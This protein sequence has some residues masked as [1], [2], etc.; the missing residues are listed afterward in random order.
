VRKANRE[1][2][3]L[4]KLQRREMGLATMLLCVVVVFLMCNVLPLVNNILESFYSKSI[5]HLVQTSNFLVVFNSS[6]NFVIYC[7]CGERFRRLLLRLCRDFLWCR[8]GLHGSRRN[9]LYR[10]SHLYRGQHGA[11]YPY[12]LTSA[13][14]LLFFFKMSFRSY[15][16]CL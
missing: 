15:I 13:S 2:Q 14:F 4:S 3:V 1:R 6:V 9:S 12:I 11:C 10:K 8:L 16:L 7:T 5:D